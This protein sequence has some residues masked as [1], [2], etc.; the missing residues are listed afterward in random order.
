MKSYSRTQ[1]TNGSLYTTVTNRLALDRE[2]TSE[3]LADLAEIDKRRMYAEAGYDSMQLYCIRVLQ[4]SEDVAGKRVRAARAARR[5]PVIYHALADGRV[6]LAAVVVLA[7]H[8]TA[9]NVDELIA[10]ATSKTRAAVELLVAQRF[11]KP[12]V[13]A[14]VQEIFVPVVSS[15]PCAQAVVPS[16]EPNAPNLL[17]PPAPGPVAPPVP[18]DVP[19]QMVPVPRFPKFTPLSPGRFAMQYTMSQ[20]AYEKL[21]RAQELLGHA[22][23]SGD[24]EQVMERAL[25]ALIT[26]LEKQKFAATSEPRTQR[27]HGMGRYIP[28]EIRR[29][30]R[31]RDGGRCTFVSDKGKRCESRKRLEIDHVI[32]IAKG[33][34]TSASNLRLLCRTHNQFEAD[35]ALGSEFMRNK[36][37]GAQR[38]PA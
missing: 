9:N 34:L 8:F 37:E 38:P 17:G 23:P 10:A 24:V 20:G 31:E 25:D 28:A 13:Q 6:H 11:P 27:S 5:Y 14:F 32:P 26:E 3:L 33:G 21:R 7:P 12:D 22:V 35:R 1:L 15:E 30:V 16:A 2:T 18:P 29:A 36:R 4:M 19:N